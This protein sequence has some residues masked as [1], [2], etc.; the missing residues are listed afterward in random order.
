MLDL[1]RLAFLRELAARGTVTAVAEALAYSP[2]A[3]SQ[4]L[5]TLQSEVGVTLLERRGR[6]VVLTAAGRALVAGAD[7]VFRAAERAANTAQ[8]AADDVVGPVSIGA[9]PGVGATVVPTAVAALRGA[10][11]D[12]EV[13]YRQIADDGLRQ[14]QLGHIDVWIDQRYTTMPG[15]V[16]PHTVERTLLTEPVCL[17]V[18]EGQDRGADLRAYREAD[19]VGMTP[20]SACRQVLE[21]LCGDAG[22]EPHEP[23]EADDLEVILQFVAAGIAV[24]VLPRQAMALVPE[25][26][27][28][29]PMSGVQ[30][31]VVALVR[32]SSD[33]RPAVALVLE[34]LCRA[35]QAAG[36]LTPEKAMA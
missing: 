20:G 35:G 4:Q 22:F 34:E 14:V 10:H 1:Q 36:R 26:V 3:V 17:A 9:F 28:V 21:R 16:A 11:P 24:A 33:Q 25:G 2:S 8:A 5:T 31:Q 23:Y 32:E 19:W 13:T 15:P 18:A 30:R 27:T 12:L 29:H 6:R 7:E